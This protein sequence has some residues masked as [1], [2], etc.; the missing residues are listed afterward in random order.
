LRSDPLTPDPSVVLARLAREYE[1]P[2]HGNPKNVF[3]C[4]VYVLL[5]AQTTLEQASLAL[6]RI[7]RRWRTP[8]ALSRAERRLIFG[9]V[10]SCGFGQ[11]RAGKVLALSRAVAEKPRGL[12]PLSRLSDE[13]VEEELTALPGVAY[14]SARVVAAMSSLE[15]DRFAVD[16]HVW[17][18]SRRLGWSSARSRDPK[19]TKPQADRLESLIPR[20]HRRQLHACLVALGR[21]SC[22]AQRPDCRVCPLNDLCGHAAR[23][24]AVRA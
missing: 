6:G 11:T 21:T 15:R 12:R 7:R 2:R 9:A 24:R 23:R 13:E 22:R 3:W 18:I 19:P 8:S 14:K 16:T 1:F 5:T 20:E 4:A 10:R 17:R